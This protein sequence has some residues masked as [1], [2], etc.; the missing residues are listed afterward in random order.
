MS[1]VDRWGLTLEVVPVSELDSAWIAGVLVGLC[2]FWH[3][4][5][6]RKSA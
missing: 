3:W 2:A 4:R 6:R 5:L 1:T